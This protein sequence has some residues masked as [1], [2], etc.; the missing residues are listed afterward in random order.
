MSLDEYRRRRNFDR[1]SEP[2]G[3]T[4][5]KSPRDRRFV[6]QLHHAR[7]RHFDFRLELDGAL[8]SWAVP[9]GPSLRPADKRLAVQVEDHPLAYGGFEGRIPEGEYGAGEV[10]IVEQ[11]TW[12]P[13]GDA[14]RALADGKLDFRLEGRHLKGRWSLVRTGP[15]AKKAK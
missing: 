10:R 7:A 5:R 14:A 3:S 9:K 6:V 2:A 15:P 11:G 1:T 4:G 12:Q 8:R 13:D